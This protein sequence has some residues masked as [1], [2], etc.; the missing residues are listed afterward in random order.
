MAGAAITAYTGAMWVL[1]EVGI[2]D[3]MV[4][5]RAFAIPLPESTPEKTPAP[6]VMMAVGSTS[7]ARSSRRS[8]QSFTSL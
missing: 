1:R 5:A 7:G 3:A 6:I 8:E 2:R 4:F